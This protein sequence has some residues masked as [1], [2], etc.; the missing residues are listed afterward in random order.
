MITTPSSAGLGGAAVVVA[1]FPF[2]KESMF[3]LLLAVSLLGIF[4][5]VAFG[6]S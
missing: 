1:S 4:S 6:S 2:H 3:V 5:G